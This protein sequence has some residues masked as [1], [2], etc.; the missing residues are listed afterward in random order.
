MKYFIWTILAFLALPLSAQFNLENITCSKY[1]TRDATTQ[2]L[3]ISDPA[4]QSA[5]EQKYTFK[6]LRIYPLM[7]NETIRKLGYSMGHYTTL[8]DAIAKN[9]I[10]ITE[11]EGGRVNTLNFENISKDTI[12]VL[13]GEVV[14]GGKQDRVVSNDLLLIPGSGVTQVTVF[15]V[16]HGRW[17]PNGTGETFKGYYGL[18]TA[19]VRKK[20]VVDKNQ[21]EVWAKVA[22]V[23]LKNSVDP[24]TGTYTALAKSD[25][26]NAE[27]DGYLKFFKPLLLA[28]SNIIGF[29]AVTGDTIIGCDLFASN[30]L[31]KAH[32]ESLVK[33]AAVEASTNGSKVKIAAAAVLAFLAEFLGSETNQEEVV[34]SSGA[35]IKSNGTNVHMNYYKKTE[36][37]ATPK[38]IIPR[39]GE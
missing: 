6:N 38:L 23:N 24:S 17:T 9:K 30:D 13:A 5:E 25:S 12:L 33:A 29:V 1:T 10:R 20:A 4:A 36:P 21:S 39:L 2:A 15:C 37:S 18:T 34:K 35:I 16:E 11:M 26:L 14:T 28:D 7:G 3:T 19:A 8:Q 31:F 22:E 32:S 27:I